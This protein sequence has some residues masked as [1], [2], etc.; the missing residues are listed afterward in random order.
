[1]DKNRIYT[2]IAFRYKAF[3][4][5]QTLTYIMSYLKAGSGIASVLSITFGAHLAQSHALVTM[6][7]EK[8]RVRERGIYI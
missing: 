1:V 5:I 7:K 6:I 2:S 3:S 8:K 4:V